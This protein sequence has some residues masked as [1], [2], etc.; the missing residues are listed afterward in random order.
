MEHRFTGP[1][2][3]SF[4]FLV[5]K[6]TRESPRPADEKPFFHNDY[7]QFSGS[8]QDVPEW[9]CSCADVDQL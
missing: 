5:K 3:I 7:S 1:S 9:V 4:F 6:D 2:L 8:A